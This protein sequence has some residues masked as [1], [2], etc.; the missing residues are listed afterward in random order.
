M[1]KRGQ[2]N[3]NTGDFS[4]EAPTEKN[5]NMFQRIIQGIVMAIFLF[6]FAPIL[7]SIS[8]SMQPLV[9]GNPLIC[10]FFKFIVPATILGGIFGI[11]KYIWRDN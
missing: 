11:L 2:M 8:D 4:Q 5:T 6:I 3:F 10:L 9:C 1:D 7:V